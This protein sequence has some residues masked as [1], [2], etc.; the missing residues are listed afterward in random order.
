M[1]SKRAKRFC[2]VWDMAFKVMRYCSLWGYGGGGGGGGGGG[3]REYKIVMRR[4]NNAWFWWL[5][6]ITFDGT[7]HTPTA[8]N[9]F[10]RSNDTYPTAPSSRDSD[11]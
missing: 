6:T 7:I 3:T 2:G 4:R 1:M 10:L 5:D 9:F 11:S 8:L